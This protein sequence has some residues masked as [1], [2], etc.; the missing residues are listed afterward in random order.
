M[1]M[2]RRNR[3]DKTEVAYK[4]SKAHRR[5]IAKHK[6]IFSVIFINIAVFSVAMMIALGICMISFPLYTEENTRVVE[7]K[8]V[9][10]EFEEVGY[11]GATCVIITLD[12]GEAF[13][14]GSE[15][16]KYHFDSSFLE[17]PQNTHITIRYSEKLTAGERTLV[18][19]QDS[20]NVYL[21]F[22]DSQKSQVIQWAVMFLCCFFMYSFFGLISFIDLSIYLQE[23]KYLIDVR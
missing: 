18:E 1:F 7:G 14:I 2:G 13:A 6:K 21:D 15:V 12:N 20:Q 4:G 8:Y 9:C 17:I 23:K 3:L 11:R 10:V 16:R 22:K 19:L 5:R